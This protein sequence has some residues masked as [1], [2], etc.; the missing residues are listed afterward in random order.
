MFPELSL[1][2]YHRRKW[3]DFFK[4][5]FW[6][7]EV[8][9]NVSFLAKIHIIWGGKKYFI[10]YDETECS[11]VAMLKW[12]CLL[13]IAITVSIMIHNCTF[14]PLVCISLLSW[15]YI[16]SKSINYITTWKSMYI[17]CLKII[18][19]YL[20]KRDLLYL[21]QNFFDCCKYS[22][23]HTQAVSIALDINVWSILNIWRSPWSQWKI[24]PSSAPLKTVPS[25]QADSY[26][27]GVCDRSVCQQQTCGLCFSL[28]FWQ[29]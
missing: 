15:H 24:I 13:Q 21:L 1:V 17:N 6:Q 10:G 7:L 9:V 14:F 18:V 19:T 23:L 27:C 26:A 2:S 22:N 16:N 4:N 8:E 28:F 25:G 12:N 5:R 3:F 20:E 29:K 11:L